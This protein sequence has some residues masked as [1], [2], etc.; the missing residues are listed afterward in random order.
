MSQITVVPLD[1]GDP[2]VAWRDGTPNLSVTEARAAEVLIGGR[3][4]LTPE[5]PF[6]TAGWD[7]IESAY[8]L[9]R[10]LFPRAR[11]DEEPRLTVLDRPAGEV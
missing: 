4:P 10:A 6:R 7:D 8:A 9:L 1:D 2:F 5:G 3:C 11:L